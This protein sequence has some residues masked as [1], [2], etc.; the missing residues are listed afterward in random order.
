[1]IRLSFK[2]EI[3]I[4]SKVSREGNYIYFTTLDNDHYSI[5]FSF[6]N[7]AIYCMNCVRKNGYAN[8]KGWHFLKK[9]K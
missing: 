7:D 4:A 1:M 9:E 5:L 6:V 8:I 2:D 3:Y